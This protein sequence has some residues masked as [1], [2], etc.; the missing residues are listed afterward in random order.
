MNP[1]DKELLKWALLNTTK[2]AI[3]PIICLSIVTTAL[4][5]EISYQEDKR[6][7]EYNPTIV[8]SRHKAYAHSIDKGL[9]YMYALFCGASLGIGTGFDTAMQLQKKQRQREE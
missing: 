5:G 3:L 8:V 9:L 6:N 7:A 2:K 1:K 4:T